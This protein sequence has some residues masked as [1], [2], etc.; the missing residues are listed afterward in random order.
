MIDHKTS[1]KKVAIVAGIGPGLGIALC[2]LL[3][4][5]GYLVAGLSRTKHPKIDMGDD[6]L[7]INCELSDQFSV[8]SAITR[9]EKI[10][11]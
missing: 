4:A 2:K 5:E 8:H 6:Y 1:Q 10:H 9:V 7:S 11:G 3:L